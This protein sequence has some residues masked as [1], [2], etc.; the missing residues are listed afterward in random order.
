MA[1]CPQPAPNS[2]FAN[3]AIIAAFANCV[4]SVRTEKLIIQLKK[5]FRFN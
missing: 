1:E 2:L 4:K 5:H 3:T